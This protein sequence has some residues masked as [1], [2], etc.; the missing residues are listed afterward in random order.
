MKAYFVSDRDKR[1]DVFVLPENDAL[2]KADKDSMFYFISAQPDF[3]KWQG[4]PLNNRTPD[5]FGIVVA[6]RQ[7]KGDVCIHEEALWQERMNHWL[8]SP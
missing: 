2:I 6:S 3:S 1:S 4:E 8:S 5:S 7:D